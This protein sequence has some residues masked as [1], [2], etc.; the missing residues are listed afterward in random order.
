[1][2]LETRNCLSRGVIEKLVRNALIESF[3]L[4]ARALV[5]FFNGKKGA[6]AAAFADDDYKPF[7][8]GHDLGDLIVKVNTQIVHLTGKRTANQNEKINHRDRE[9][10]LQGV[11]AEVTNFLRHL[12]PE[13]HPLWPEL[14]WS[15]IVVGTSLGILTTTST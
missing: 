12:K 6:D 10:L 5:D 1:M 11:W 9:T 4:H 15:P 7:P 8:D 2:L 13:Y 3:C 14:T